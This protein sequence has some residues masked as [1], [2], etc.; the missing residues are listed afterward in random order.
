MFTPR[1]PPREPR[2][3]WPF[4]LALKCT[5]IVSRRA[6][7]TEDSLTPSP[8]PTSRSVR[9]SFLS[10]V[11]ACW[12][13]SLERDHSGLFFLHCL[14][15]RRGTF[16]LPPAAGIR[17]ASS[18]GVALGDANQFAA[19]PNIRTFNTTPPPPATVRISESCRGPA[20][21]SIRP[22]ITESRDPSRTWCTNQL[23]TDDQKTIIDSARLS[24]A[25]RPRIH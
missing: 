6:E 19:L 18:H 14:V 8:P 23:R 16:P 4:S 3:L 15:A 10:P 25:P 22:E 1:Q 13:A 20:G 21:N 24:R 12:Q 9:R 5:C 2:S 17:A 7:T 11:D